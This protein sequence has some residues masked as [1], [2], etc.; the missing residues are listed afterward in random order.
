MLLWA[1][2]Q[3]CNA[4]VL[5]QVAAHAACCESQHDTCAPWR[6]IT[7]STL[8]LSSW[9]MTCILH[10]TWPFNC[11][12]MCVL[13]A[14]A[15]L[16]LGSRRGLQAGAGGADRPLCALP[17]ARWA[18]SRVEEGR[19]WDGLCQV[20]VAGAEEGSVRH[21]F[22]CALGACSVGQPSCSSP[23]L[24][25]GLVGF[26]FASVSSANVCTS[27]AHLLLQPITTATASGTPFC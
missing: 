2:A 9:E 24:R 7:Q 26:L 1:A 10:C 17:A 23:V 6:C 19:C 25:S 16:K 20:C 11:A 22:G 14:C 8:L 27:A 13:P 4:H 18:A 15:L 12:S 21:V 3:R 5:L